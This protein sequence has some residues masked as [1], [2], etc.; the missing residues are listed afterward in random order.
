M[1][2]IPKRLREAR[3]ETPRKEVCEALGIAPSTLTMYETGQRV[4]R[5]EIKIALANFYNTSVEA[6]FY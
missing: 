6:L 5:D 3:G 4:P 2:D 1:R